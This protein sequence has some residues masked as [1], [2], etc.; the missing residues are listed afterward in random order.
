MKHVTA[1]MLLLSA[2]PL[3]ASP[4]TFSFLT[5]DWTMPGIGLQTGFVSQ[6]PANS[7]NMSTGTAT[8][9]GVTL[10]FIATF[11]NSTSGANFGTSSVGSSMTN[12]VATNPSGFLMSTAQNDSPGISTDHPNNVTLRSPASGT[13]TDYQR[14]HF[15]FSEPIVLQAFNIDD[16]DNE[17]NSGQGGFQDILGAEAFLDSGYTPGVTPTAGSG[18]NPT[19]TLGS[20]LV[21]GALTLGSENIQVVSPNATTG[22]PSSTPNVRANVTFGDTPIRA[23]SIYAFSDLNAVHRMTLS[24]HSF[25]LATVPEPSSVLFGL[26][27]VCGILIHRRR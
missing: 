3:T 27:S 16:I 13:A 1:F 6:T 8:K 2:L 20:S 23:F 18:I 7:S 14:W 17:N 22:N 21:E 9:S 5:D 19:F 25:T 26:L 4:I 15:E 12:G 10:T 11:V 24:N